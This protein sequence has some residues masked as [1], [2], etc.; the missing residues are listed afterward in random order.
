MSSFNSIKLND[1]S[2]TGEVLPADY[3]L[4]EDETGTKRIGY[5]FFILQ[6]SNTSFYTAFETIS[7][8]LMPL[9]GEIDTFKSSISGTSRITTSTAV[10]GLSVTIDG[11]YKKIYYTTGTFNIPANVIDS[12]TTRFTVSGGV[13]L[14]GFDVRLTFGSNSFAAISG[15]VVT[16]FPLLSTVSPRVYDLRVRLTGPSTFPTIVNYNIFK[17]Y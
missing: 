5:N 14:S 1:L 17:L 8:S 13:T 3:L 4:I 6:K 9:S 10:S 7:S 15:R 16:V 11:E 12:L 2:R